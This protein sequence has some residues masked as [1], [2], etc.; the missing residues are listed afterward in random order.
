MAD[1]SGKPPHDEDATVLHVDP[2][3]VDVPRGEA[4]TVAIDNRAA[5][6]QAARQA[7]RSRAFDAEAPTE[8]EG[9][10]VELD[11]SPPEIAPG[12]IL[13]GEYEVGARIGAGGMGEVYRA[14]HRRLGEDRAIK[15]IRPIYTANN[16]A[17]RLFDREARS[18]L[19]IHHPAVVRCHDMLSD[20][21]GRVYLVMEFVEGHSLAERLLDGPLKPR[22]IEELAARM[23][24]GLAAAHREGVVHRDL[25]PDNVVL[26]GGSFAD[27]KLIDFG[28]AKEVERSETTILDGFKGKVLY[29]SPE[30]IGYFDGEVD[31]RSDY[32]SLGLV[33]AAA[34][35]GDPIPMGGTLI[36]AVEARRE[37]PILPR[38]IPD[39]IRRMIQP[40]L[41]VDP[42]RRPDS[43][44]GLMLR[45]KEAAVGPS[46]GS[47]GGRGRAALLGG[48]GA[49]AATVS[50]LWLWETQT[51]QAP[52]EIAAPALARELPAPPSEPV[53]PVPPSVVPAPEPVAES[54]LEPAAKA[55]ARAVAK[56]KGPSA[57]DRAAA[58][59]RELRIEGLMAGARAAVADGRL[60][61]PPGDNAVEKLEAVLKLDP[62]NSEARSSMDT[63]GGRYLEMADSAI[64][65]GDVETARGYIDTAAKLAPAH[66]ALSSTRAA[67]AGAQ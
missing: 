2:T 58:L 62:S 28:I 8:Y 11:Q 7:E 4:A 29:A 64:D 49:V 42:S 32:F 9:T 24:S 67:L 18:L 57:S 34:A 3:D 26:P 20:E 51:T 41:E 46:A 19:K 53:A 13:F 35:L 6:D 21:T 23:A 50:G 56:P 30:Q 54:P 66:P 1:D 25:S 61:S 36:Q 5:G 55:V 17:A 47:A 27:A 43:L 39:K 37:T 52:P 10:A 40:L 44:D 60:T 22:Q 12:T 65:G 38:E 63:L 15:M 16:A 48:L 31:R 14:R 59:R 33:L 45:T